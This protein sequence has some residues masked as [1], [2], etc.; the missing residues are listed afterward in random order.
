MNK[1][2]T[3]IIKH[4]D[5]EL[6]IKVVMKDNLLRVTTEI[7]QEFSRKVSLITNDYNQD[8]V[9]NI[10]RYLYKGSTLELPHPEDFSGQI[11]I[12]IEMDKPDSKEVYK[13]RVDIITT[14]DV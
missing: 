10:E 8:K 5:N 1:E 2:I 7:N 6:S 12:D 13:H 14:I 9:E 11:Y 3:E 4:E